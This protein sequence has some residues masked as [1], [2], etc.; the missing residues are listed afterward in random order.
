MVWAGAN[1]SSYQQA[2]EALRQLGDYDLTLKRIRRVTTQ[3]GSERLQERQ[4]E[5]TAFRE[6][7]LTDRYRSP[8]PDGEDRLLVVMMDGGRYQRRDQFPP[9]PRTSERR[10]HWKEDKIGIVLQ[11]RGP[12][13]RQD[14]C[15][16]FPEWLL[17]ATAVQELARLAERPEP[18]EQ[19]EAVGEVPSGW[20]YPAPQLLSREVIASSEGVEDFGWHLQWKAFLSGS[21]SYSRQAFVADGASVNWRVHREHFSELT[22][23]LD[24]MH[25]LSYAW[26]AA[27]GLHVEGQFSRAD[28]RRWAERLWQGRVSEVIA[29]L[30]THQER[31]GEPADRSN[32]SDPAVR[33]ERAVTYYEH[34][35]SRMRYDQY[36]QAGLP[37]TSS[38][39]ESTIK[40]INRRLKGSEKFWNAEEGEAVLQL[41]AD[42]LSDSR[43]LDVFWRLQQSRQNGSNRYRTSV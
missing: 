20:S 2:Q 4:R 24:L 28:Y 35:Q 31:L 15:P 38:P 26:R 41:R 7:P 37:L 34:H 32:G 8:Q 1:L 10:G 27:D 36:R 17:S 42:C 5:V 40:L 14:P 6:Q 12:C 19:A 9:A 23:I 11:M 22:A 30:K 16:E 33:V 43:P 39:V 25:A 18:L 29:E 21:G 3:T 13:H